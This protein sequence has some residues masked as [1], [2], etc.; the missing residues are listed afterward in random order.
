MDKETISIT[1]AEEQFFVTRFN[2][3]KVG[4]FTYTTSVYPTEKVEDAIKRAHKELHQLADKLFLIKRNAYMERLGT[5]S[6][7]E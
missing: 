3:F 7:Q 1:Y 2:S 5:I 6:K 4:P